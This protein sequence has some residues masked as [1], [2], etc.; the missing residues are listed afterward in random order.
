MRLP[1]IAAVAV[2]ATASGASARP[3]MSGEAELAGLLSGRAAGQPLECIRTYRNDSVRTIDRT[4]LVFGRGDTIYVNRTR[5][6]R[7][8]DDNDA[9]VIR[10][11]G[12]GSNLCRTDLITTFDRTSRAYSGNVFLTEF[13]PYKRIRR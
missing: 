7:S 3:G 13:V 10:K 1:I 2:L 9:L 6:P 11:F 12:T 8:L 4:A 5:N